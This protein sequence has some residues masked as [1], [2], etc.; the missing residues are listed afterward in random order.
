V[1]SASSSVEQRGQIIK[2][3]ELAQPPPGAIEISE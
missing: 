2:L 3:D 1:C